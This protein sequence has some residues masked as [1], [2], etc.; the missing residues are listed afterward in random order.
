MQK[1]DFFI[2]QANENLSARTG[3]Y[4]S[5]LNRPVILGV[6]AFVILATLF[7]ALIYQRFL[8]L[9]EAKEKDAYD[10]V[11]NAKDKLQEV[12]A[13][14][15]SATKTLSFFIDNNG[16]LKNF[17]SVA[18]QILN[19]NKG[20]DALE[21]VP[22][23]IIQNVYPL[24]GNEKA[25]GYN[26][27]K[28]RA[29][30]KEAYKTIEKK[31]L[32][33]SGPFELKQGGIGIVGRL[34]VFRNKKFWGF[35]AVIIKLPTLLKA[36][37]IDSMDRHGNYFQLSKINPDTKKEEFFIP[38]QQEISQDYSISVDVPD[39]EWKLSVKPAKGYRGLANVF[40]LGLLGFLISIFGGL[41]I[42]SVVGRPKMLNDLVKERTMQMK[43]SEEK[44]SS[45][46]HSNV[47]GFAIYDEDFRIVDINE[48]YAAILESDRNNLIGKSSDEAGLISKINI[49]KRKATSDEIEALLNMYG[50]LS[51]FETAIETKSGEPVIVL[52]SIEQM[53]LNNKK[54]WLTSIIDITAMKKAELL[55]KEN[56]EKYRTLIEQASDGIVITDLDG[57]ILEVNNSICIMSGYSEQEMLG[58]HL[59]K[60]LPAED[61]TL[62]PIRINELMQ[63]KS[64]LYERRLLRKDGSSL[65]IE[66]NSKMAS[67][68][69]LIGFIRDITD[70]KKNDETLRYQARLLESV[71]D[72]I[73]SLDMNRKIVSWN[74]ACEELYGFKAEE[75]FGKR[76]RE[77]VTFEFPFTT[78]EEVFKQVYSEGQWKGEFNFIHPKTKV[79]T[80]LLSSLSVLKNKAGDITGIMLTSKDITERKKREEEIN[81]SNERFELIAQATNEAVWDHDFK[82]NETWGNKKLYDLYGYGSETEKIS[83]EMFLERIHPDE[84]DDVVVRL[85]KAIENAVTSLTEE[86]RFKTTTGEYKNFYDRAYIKY[87]EGGKPLR[88]LGAMQ[89]ITEREN[90]K[91]AIVESEEKFSKAFH[92]S[93]LGL[94]LYDSD[95]RIVDTNNV[96]AAILE[97]TPAEL[98][99]KTSGEAG[100]ESKVNPAKRTALDQKFDDIFNT[101][102]RL[103]NFEMEIETNNGQLV[104]VLVSMEPLELNNK[105]YWL[106]SAMDITDK[107]K[108]ELLLTESEEKY[109][110]LVEQANDGIF[111]ADK[112][113][114]FLIVNSSGYNMSQYSPEEL[115]NMSIYDLVLPADIKN[116]PFH[117]SEMA[118]NKVA[119]AERRL[120]RKDGTLLDVEVTAKFISGNRFLAFVRD[121]S[122]SKKAD[123]ALRESEERYRALVENAPEALVVMDV[124]KQKFISVSESATKLFKMSKEELLKVGPIEVSPEYQPEGRRSSE[125]VMEKLAEAMAGGKP[126]FEWTHCDKAGNLVPCEI[127]LVRLPSDNEVLIRGSIVDIS[128][129]KLAE[130]VLQES[131]KFLKETQFIAKLGTYTLDIASAKWKSSE[132]LDEIFGIDTDFDKTYENW[133]TII[134]PEWRQIMT[135]YF[136]QEVIGNKTKFDKEYKIIRINDKT[137]RWVYGIGNLKFNDNN[138]PITMVGT[139]HDITERKEAEAVIYQSEQK[140]RLLFYNNPLPMWMSTIPDL[141]IIEVNEAAIKHYGYTRDEFIKLNAKDL[142]PAEDVEHFVAEVKKMKQG[143]NNT[144]AWRHKKKDGTI[145]HVE[146]FSHDIMYEGRRVWLGLSND[147]TGKYNA[148]ELLQKSYEEI[149]QLASNLQSIREDER[150]NIARE[151]H[152]ELG[153]QLTG[154]KMDLHW[155]SRKIKDKDKE[156]HNKMKESI[157][158]IN[159]TIT[160]VRKIATDLRPSILD[161]LGLIAALEWQGEEFEKRSGTK[162]EFINQVGDLPVR[163]EVATGIF[164]I[165]QELLTNIARHANARLVSASLYT[166]EKTLWFSI[167]DNGVGF[168][169][170]TIGNK[171]TLGLLGIKERTLLMG[172]TYEIKTQTGEGSE[173][174]I[175]IPL[176]LI[177]FM[178]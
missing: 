8:I 68:H 90:T 5:I 70:R 91:R 126:S 152:D 125:L 11:N 13:Y 77:L 168:N 87:D 154:L 145:I 55:L 28:D 85:R 26:I 165:Y 115:K 149:R 150:T 33:F 170:D 89:D 10:M 132:I 75:V 36:A 12:L 147:V 57:N 123:K 52:L 143:I 72:A 20:I 81:I 71:S 64:L 156:I 130:E 24:K 139:I 58:E 107:K 79:K 29:R 2:N 177:K 102:G 175:S 167:K 34:P 116:D 95:F 73:T 110:T 103:N 140:Y 104:T 171:K 66:V 157:E 92:S 60:F 158:L 155:L 109:R 131:E 38:H 101:E 141:D 37:R 133:Q 117:F 106:T 105:K 59:Y 15:L 65:D 135:D 134:H 41:F 40:I 100:M 121:V 172:G 86:F 118:G 78:T 21:L 7:T 4:N 25:I 96:Y 163:A 98:I 93:L 142:R 128:K 146:I 18:A 161:D 94:A 45:A 151:I 54:H 46:F 83:F 22:D 148:R 169:A 3:K 162:V 49:E 99:G 159:A 63:G 84:R 1:Q 164:R 23:G 97:S 173:T 62:N 51:N 6:S 119:R 174:I 74:K 127:W 129:R 113:G 111:I 138:E 17:D 43:E 35:T 53:E 61:A 80:Y 176:E 76:I 48:P 14:S 88:I 44:F 144:R 69:T 67:S 108:A 124:K 9:K 50:Q 27:L 120:K 166:D 112:E 56:E 137:E 160:S 42:F 82:K 136:I 19:A 122:E 47:L 30:N 39:G 31:E 153:Q 32:F 114:R 16:V 178:G